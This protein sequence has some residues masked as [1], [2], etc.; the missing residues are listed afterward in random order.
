VTPRKPTLHDA[1]AAETKPFDALNR[2][3][4]WRTILGAAAVIGGVIG[5]SKGC[6]NRRS[7]S[8]GWSNAGEVAVWVAWLPSWTGSTSSNKPR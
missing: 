4:T 3:G 7:Q 1:S 8:C 2:A 6:E 5:S